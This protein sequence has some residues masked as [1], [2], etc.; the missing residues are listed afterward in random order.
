MQAPDSPVAGLFVAGLGY[1][2]G[3]LDLRKHPPIAAVIHTTGGG[4]LTRFAREGA[5]K[6]DATSFET[7]VRVY[8]QIMGASGHYVVGQLGQCTQVV[9]ESFSAWHVGAAKSK[10]YALPQAEWMTHALAWWG[11]RWPGLNSPRDLAGGLLWRD[12]SCNANVV[13]IE[14]VP[15]VSGARHLW[16]PE[17]WV[18]LARLV[19]DIAR[20]H[21]IAEDREH[22]I[23]HSDAH[24]IARS[25]KGAPWDPP[26]TQFDW[27]RMRKALDDLKC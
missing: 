11:E 12:G 15:P 6:G 7:A 19:R 16:S 24:P 8:T 3:L 18:T 20:R 2:Q 5:R 22:V 9:P 1:R 4:V 17:C 14:V 10:P 25:A 21:V 27:A 13:G 23:S 26:S